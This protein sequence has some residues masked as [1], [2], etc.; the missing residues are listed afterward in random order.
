LE[1]GHASD[2]PQGE[3]TKKIKAAVKYKNAL[4]ND[5]RKFC[6]KSLEKRILRLI[7][8]SLYEPGKEKI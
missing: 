2:R 6:G 3:K 1:R 5:K 4:F 8:S 7:L